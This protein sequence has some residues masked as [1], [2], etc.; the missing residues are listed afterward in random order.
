V[1]LVTATSYAEDALAQ[2]GGRQIS[3]YRADGLSPAEVLHCLRA[4]VGVREPHYDER[5]VPEAATVGRETSSVKR[6]T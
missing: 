3:L 2:R 4:M 6:E 1:V 5:A